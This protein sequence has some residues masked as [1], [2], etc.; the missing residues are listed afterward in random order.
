MTLAESQLG[1]SHQRGRR[2]ALRWSDVVMD[3]DNPH[4]NI[5]ATLTYTPGQPLR[6][7]PTKTRG[8]TRN[9]YLVPK[10]SRCS[11]HAPST[12]RSTQP[13]TPLCSDRRKHPDSFRDPNNL[14]RSI[15][16]IFNRH[17]V[18]WGRSH[19]G[20]KF[21]VNHLLR[22][23]V[24]L[25]EIARVVGWSD[26][27]TVS[28]YADTSG[29]IGMATRVAMEA[30]LATRADSAYDGWRRLIQTLSAP[31]RCRQLH[32]SHVVR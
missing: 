4:I 23:H 9:V 31:I 29:E 8:G 3:G 27:L 15:R 25:P 6:R 30:T 18:T 21:V 10:P 11:G 7:T 14:N 5:Q 24:P 28:K 13:A 26:V 17:G 2:Q 22:Q 12:S 32:R 16:I 1:W 20:R 19:I